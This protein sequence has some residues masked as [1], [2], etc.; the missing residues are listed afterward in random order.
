MQKTYKNDTSR[1]RQVE[2]EG[3]ILKWMAR[4]YLWQ[5]AL[6]EDIEKASVN[7][8]LVIATGVR[9]KWHYIIHARVLWLAYNICIL[10]GFQK[11]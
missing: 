6:D 7:V 5:P 4:S 1:I 9:Q 11:K 3:S 2:L 8:T 10:G